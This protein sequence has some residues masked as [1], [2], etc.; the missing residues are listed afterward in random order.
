MS[1]KLTIK[2]AVE[3]IPVSESTL[4]RDLKSGKVS[5]E[6]DLQGRRR[7]DA[8]ELT[9]A[10]GELKHQ[11][12]A[13]LTH[14]EDVSESQMNADDTPKVISLLEG[15]VQDLKAQLETATTEKAQLLALSDSLQKQNDRL[16]KQNETLMLPPAP[17]QKERKS[18]GWHA[19]S[20]RR[21]IALS[22]KQLAF[23][24]TFLIHS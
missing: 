19:T 15:Q 9:R 5:S 4:R 18:I 10:Y 17:E 21:A 22:P 8:S 23:F 7:I 14:S 20:D 24:F 16:Q 3:V 12:G 13:P 11:N 2:E 1:T 6:K